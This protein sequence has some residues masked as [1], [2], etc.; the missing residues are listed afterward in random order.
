[1][2]KLTPTAT[3]KT[4]VKFGFRYI[5]IYPTVN[6]AHAHLLDHLHDRLHDHLL[7]HLH[8]HLLD[9]LH[10]RLHDHLH[11]RLHDHLHDRLHD[12][13]HDRIC[14]FSADDYTAGFMAINAMVHHDGLI[15]WLPPA[16]LKSSCKVDI[17]YFPFDHQVREV[18][19]LT[20]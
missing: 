12:H 6:G 19:S 2:C 17:T 9:R 11:D 8:D 14:T 13:L 4:P 15:S 5:R 3:Y 10:D 20:I 16:R 7:D 18:N 1:M